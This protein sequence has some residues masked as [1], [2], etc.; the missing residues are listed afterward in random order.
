MG[1]CVNFTDINEIVTC[2]EGDNVPGTSCE[3]EI[4]LA[5]DVVTWPDFPAASGDTG[6]SFAEAGAISGNLTLKKGASRC[7]LT[8]TRNTGEFTMTD[9]G[10]PGSENVLYALALERSKMS[11]EIFGFLNATRGRRLWIKA[12]D[13]NGQTYLMGDKVNQAYR[14]AGDAATTGKATTDANRVPMRF[15]YVCPRNLVFDGDIEELNS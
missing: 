14:V 2:S 4:G 3:V 5:D 13:K 9:Q 11:A 6:M 1:K 15:E 12:T 8:F 10:E 7:K